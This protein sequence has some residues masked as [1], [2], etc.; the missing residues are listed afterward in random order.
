MRSF[1]TK[2]TI[3]LINQYK[4]TMRF[5]LPD[6]RQILLQAPSD[7]ELNSWLS[8]INYA[9]AFK[10][11][12]IRMRPLG[13]SGEDVLLTGVAAATS[14]L[15]DLQQH[16]D[17]RKR[18]S[19]DSD[20][21]QDLMD[22]L[23]LPNHSKSRLTRRFTLSELSEFDMDVPVAPEIDGAEQFKATFD[24]VKA[25][26]AA[27][28]WSSLDDAP[29]LSQ[30]EDAE[31]NIAESPPTSPGSSISNSSHLPSRSQII[32][33]K[34]RHINSKVHA[35]QAQY[36]ADMRYVRN[37]AILT[38]FQK[39]TRARLSSAIQGVAKRIN[40]VRLDR[41]RL[42]CHRHVLA[43]DLASEDRSWSRS[44]QMALRA[45]KE[46]LQSR[47]SQNV[48]TMTLSLLDDT[49]GASR[50]LASPAL[51]TPE[52]TTCESFYSAQDFGPAWSSKSDSS[53]KFP[54][55][56][57]ASFPLLQYQSQ[58]QMRNSLNSSLTS[59]SGRASSSFDQVDD[60]R[61]DSFNHDHTCH[62][63]DEEAE[64]WNR[65]KC[66]QRVSLVHVPSS[67]MLSRLRGAIDP[68]R[69]PG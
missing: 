69:L 45:A 32:Q 42:H 27:S 38:P 3:N 4:H 51:P 31:N 9:S 24:Q 30:E 53:Q 8:R 43:C 55:R 5:V 52:S 68:N 12:G 65:T 29:W 26:L 61:Q 11:A 54:L 67:I 34:I 50:A 62:G 41:A 13:L 44:K 39:S 40:L 63:D 10:S 64:E 25:D 21:G 20:V 36:D 37:I 66:A 15:H 60:Q 58:E 46:T 56:A 59:A 16:S 17:T 18:K 14:H 33:S 19:W 28:S 47:C 1:I 6:G 35:S 22:M 48:P 57:S 7:T 2:F 49:A 23:S